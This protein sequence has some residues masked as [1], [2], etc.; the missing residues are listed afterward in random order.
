[1]VPVASW[2]LALKT[3]W[4]FLFALV[5]LVMTAPLLLLAMALVKLTTRGPVF[6]CQTR[7]GRGG[8]PFILYKLRSMIHQCETL[9]GPCWAKPGD[10]RITRV[11]RW[12]RRLHLDELPQLWNVLKGDMSLIGPR[13]ERPEFVPKLTRV[14]PL[15]HGRLQARPG[16][17]GLAQV[18]LPADSDLASVRL[19]LAYDLY[20]VQHVNWWLDMRILPATILHLAGVPF[21]WI[22]R[23]L[24]FPEIS[25]IEQEYQRLID[26]G[27]K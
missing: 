27:A 14:I 23:V 3:A 15:Y 24:G 25:V 12:L 17:T 4:E 16:L 22:R 10:A 2:Y 5:L 6:Y 21:A 18:Q 20:Y 11:G 13:P 9:T 1:L 8:R 26:A 7:V 19:K